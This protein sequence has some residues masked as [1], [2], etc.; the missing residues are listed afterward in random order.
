MTYKSIKT[1]FLLFIFIT[2][3]SSCN[4]YKIIN[5]EEVLKTNN[6][7]PFELEGNKMYVNVVIENGVE[8]KL[9]FDT[10]ATKNILFDTLLIPN[11]SSKQ[12]VNFGKTKLP[13]GSAVKNSL[14]AV[15]MKSQMFDFKSYA[16]GVVQ[17][18]S[19][20]C[21]ENSKK[22]LIGSYPL[23]ILFNGGL[24]QIDF[25][26][27]KIVFLE[28]SEL[29]AKKQI[30]F[31]EVKTKFIKSNSHFLVYLTINGVEEPFLFDTG[32]SSFPI[33]VSSKS[34][35]KSELPFS[36]YDGALLSLANGKHNDANNLIKLNS[37]FK[38]ADETYETGYLKTSTFEGDYN[39]IGTAFIKNFNWIVD[40]DLQKVYFKRN[41]IQLSSPTI[42]SFEFDYKVFADPTNEL[43]II[44]KRKGLSTFE[45]ND[46]IL[47]V[48]GVL[49]DK[50]NICEFEQLLNKNKKW[51]NFDIKTKK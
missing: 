37:T 5:N 39:N 19:S 28:K 44:T 16:T 51:D 36:E 2:F 48:N 27:Q 35:I 42:S 38:I 46:K 49:I 47:S 23:P 10:G 24:L 12:K 7:Q 13:D 30:G 50:E 41:S 14:V 17:H 1:T 43:R 26:E 18:S 33:I 8:E 9:I 21:R 4:V 25:D 3:L 6:E 32:N 45:L 40:Y 20:N 22:G 31:K 29:E 11:Y 15:N 34:E